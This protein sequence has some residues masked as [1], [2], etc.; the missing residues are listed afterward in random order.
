M[1][2]GNTFDIIHNLGYHKGITKSKELA[3]DFSKWL[4]GTY[5]FF[6]SD[7]GK[8][9]HLVKETEVTDDELFDLYL[10]DT[11]S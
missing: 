3:I 4:N 2:E 7:K 8:W 10:N 5:Y 1:I 6:N 11:N 9:V